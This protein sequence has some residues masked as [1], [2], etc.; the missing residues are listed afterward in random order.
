MTYIMMTIAGF[1]VVGSVVFFA[2]LGLAAKRPM[3]APDQ[4][5]ISAPVVEC[6]PTDRQSEA[7]VWSA[8]PTPVIPRAAHSVA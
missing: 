1:W 6:L 4:M 8:A 7:E 5:D 3:P 2:A